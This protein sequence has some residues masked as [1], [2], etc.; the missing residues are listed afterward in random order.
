MA[1]MVTIRRK[2][3]HNRSIIVFKTLTLHIPVV[4][5]CGFFYYLE[6]C[7]QRCYH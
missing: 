3:P 6:L 4:A 5:Y 2:T 7:E 1:E